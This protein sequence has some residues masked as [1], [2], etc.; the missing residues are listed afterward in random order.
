M[1]ITSFLQLW[2][3]N[4][5]KTLK[6]K[7]SQKSKD[8]YCLINTK[9]WITNKKMFIKKS[10]LLTFIFSFL[11]LWTTNKSRNNQ[12]LKKIKKVTFNDFY[13]LLLLD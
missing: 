6:N 5:W 1:S 10:L 11:Q 7:K 4:N 3:T 12:K 8:F 9:F 2:T 13:W